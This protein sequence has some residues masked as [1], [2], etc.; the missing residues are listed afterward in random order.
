V[1][2]GSTVRSERSIVAFGAAKRGTPAVK[3]EADAVEFTCAAR[4][5]PK[6]KMVRSRI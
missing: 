5:N 1:R 6:S 3:N 2:R 4:E